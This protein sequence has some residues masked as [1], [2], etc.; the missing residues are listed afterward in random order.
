MPTL[1]GMDKISQVLEPH[2]DKLKKRIKEANT[3][4]ERTLDSDPGMFKPQLDG[5]LWTICPCINPSCPGQLR[6]TYSAG[7]LATIIQDS[8]ELK[9]TVDRKLWDRVQTG[10]S[11]EPEISFQDETSYIYNVQV[12]NKERQLFIVKSEIKIRH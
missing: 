2:G 7:R 12:P 8:A 11:K 9:L 5:R 10:F 3:W 6:N 4:L 1:L